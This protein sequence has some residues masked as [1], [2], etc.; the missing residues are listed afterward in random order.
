MENEYET[1]QDGKDTSGHTEITSMT[2][3]SDD[4]YDDEELDA[5][6]DAKD[7]PTTHSFDPARISF[8]IHFFFEKQL[9]SPF[10]HPLAGRVKSGI[11]KARPSRKDMMNRASKKQAEGAMLMISK[12]GDVDDNNSARITSGLEQQKRCRPLVPLEPLDKKCVRSSNNKN[13]VFLLA[14]GGQS[15]FH[16]VTIVHCH[17]FRTSTKWRTK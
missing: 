3:M 4:H 14:Q 2:L 6:I 5:L 17:H 1:Y 10:E 12:N 7:E 11:R 13:N 8:S 15:N 9:S 16:P